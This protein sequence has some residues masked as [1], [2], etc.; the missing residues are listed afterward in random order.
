MMAAQLQPYGVMDTTDA[1]LASKCV[2]LSMAVRLSTIGP[3]RSEGSTEFLPTPAAKKQTL[4]I[5]PAVVTG[6]PKSVESLCAAGGG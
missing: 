1:I 6:S 5:N 3:R 2:T 4:P